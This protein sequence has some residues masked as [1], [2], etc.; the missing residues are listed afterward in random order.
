MPEWSVSVPLHDLV[1]LSELPY[2]VEGLTSDCA[3][4]R[5]EVDG[6]RRLLCDAMQVIADLRREIEKR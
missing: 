1:A 6:L 2:R 5:H 4:L 3:Q